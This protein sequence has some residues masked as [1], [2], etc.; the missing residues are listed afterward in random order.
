VS[1]G[2]DKNSTG[3]DFVDHGIRET[4]NQQPPKLPVAHR[5]RFWGALGAIKAVIHLV[6]EFSP[7]TRNARFVEPRC[8]A[9]F[10]LSERVNQ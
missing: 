7:K 6:D 8:L 2:N 4:A 3:Q 9:Q 5:T 1:H 10:G